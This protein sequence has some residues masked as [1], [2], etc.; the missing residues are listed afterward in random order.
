MECIHCKGKL[1]RGTAP[2][3]VERQGYHIHWSNIPAWVCSQCGEP[4][5]ESQEVDTIQKAL[6]ILD[7][8]TGVLIG[9]G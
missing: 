9:R 7:A 6:A 5:F 8:E 3:N 1:K 2:F 4:Y